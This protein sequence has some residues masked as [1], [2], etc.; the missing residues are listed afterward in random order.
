MNIFPNIALR[1]ANLVIH[2]MCVQI[3]MSSLKVLSIRLCWS[4]FPLLL[5]IWKVIQLVRQLYRLFGTS[6]SAPSPRYKSPIHSPWQAD[7]W[8]NN[9][10]GDRSSFNTR[11]Q[12][13]SSC[14]CTEAE[15]SI[16][17]LAQPLHSTVF[18]L[19]ASLRHQSEIYA[20]AKWLRSV[21]LLLCG[22]FLFSPLSIS[23][24][25]RLFQD[26]WFHM[27]FLCQCLT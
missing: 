27:R 19:V 4:S 22:V 20:A 25:L 26:L 6:V 15:D 8:T 13:S 18:D 21:L 11:S 16:S 10:S 5:L 9:G 23:L 7:L 3:N 1:V 14:E 12:R 2:L 17:S 24:I